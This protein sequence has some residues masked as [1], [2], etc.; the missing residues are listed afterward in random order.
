QLRGRSGRQGDPGSS[1]FFLSLE[2]DLMRLFGAER[3]SGIM[4]K[5]GIQEGEVIEH[6]WVTKAIERAQKRVE[7]HNF[8]TR[9][10]LIEYDDVMNKQREVIYEQ[11]LRVLEG[12]SIKETM[13]EDLDAYVAGVVETNIDE[14]LPAADWD[15]RL[16]AAELELNLL[17]PFP[18][19]ALQESRLDK[20]Y[21]TEH[22]LELARKAYARKEEDLSDPIMREVERRVALSVID[23]NWRDHLHEMDLLKEGIGLRGWGQKDPLLEYKKEA[24]ATFSEMN[25]VIRVETV[26]RLFRVSLVREAPEPAR[27]PSSPMTMTHSGVSAFGP[28]EA[29]GLAGPERVGRP[30]G[31]ASM[32]SGGL[33]GNMTAR[34]SAPP[35]AGRPAGEPEIAADKVGRN[36]PCPCGSGKKFKKCHGAQ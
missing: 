13:L 29:S 6:P 33:P 11:R 28:P 19:A 9:K 32:A 23:E 26:K 31:S 25:E 24:F 22:F 16:P 3:I 34:S 36:D 15:L 27:R 1:R 10:H 14:A 30:S 35:A 7:E 20:A 18:I 2:D 5:M 21:V 12:E 17:N 8:S 4:E